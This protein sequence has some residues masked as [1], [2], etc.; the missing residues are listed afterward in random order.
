MVSLKYI[1]ILKNSVG[2]FTGSTYSPENVIRTFRKNDDTATFIVVVTLMPKE[3]V[4]A[5]NFL[6]Y[7]MTTTDFQYWEKQ[8]KL[9]MAKWLFKASGTEPLMAKDYS[10]EL[11]KR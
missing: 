7:R 6:R 11:N 3:S 4:K 10:D 9:Q 5:V 8:T 2:Y 1:Y